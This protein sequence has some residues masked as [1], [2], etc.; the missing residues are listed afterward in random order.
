MSK[1]N[2]K[3]MLQT[4]SKNDVLVSSTRSLDNYVGQESQRRR[5]WHEPERSIV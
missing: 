5:Q 4:G 1:T 3:L 2:G